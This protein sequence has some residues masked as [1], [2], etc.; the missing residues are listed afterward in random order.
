MKRNRTPLAAAALLTILPT[1]MGA[2]GGCTFLG[3]TLESPVQAIT[4]M[5]EDADGVVT[6]DLV[7]VSTEA[8]DHRFVPHAEKAQVRVPGGALVPLEPDADGHYRANSNDFPEHVYDDS[9][10]N[11]RVSFVLDD[12]DYAGDAAGEDF[13]AVVS[14]PPD[15]VSFEL[16]KAPEFAGDTARIEWSPARLTGLFEVHDDNGELVYSTFNTE[17]PDFDGS[18]WGSL[19]HLGRHDLRVDVFAD[20]GT[21]T[22]SFCAVESKEGFEEEV[23]GGLGVLSGFLAGRCAESMTIE[24]AE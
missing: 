7:V 14:P 12:A 2:D 18:K 3:D 9:G 15:E 4:I 22:L 23:S 1:L 24:V 16:V 11:Y 21:Y 5:Q 8:G 20:P 13:I 17:H 10:S 19:I 6:V